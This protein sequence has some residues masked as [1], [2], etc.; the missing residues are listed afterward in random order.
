M[1][2]A[3]LIGGAV[4]FAWFVSISFGTSNYDLAGQPLGG[5]YIDF[6]AAGVTINRGE[7]DLLYDFDYQR[8]LQ[9]EI[10]GGEF[11][12]PDVYYALITPPHYSFPFIFLSRFPYK[13]SFILWS[14]LGLGFIFA[15]I[16][17]TETED[18]KRV[19]LWSLSYFPIFA[20]ISYGQNSLLSLGL[21][22]LVYFF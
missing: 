19:F 17:L 6:H 18:P 8:L 21:F 16:L 22:S 1:K 12:E 13:V 11:S 4:W 3:W 15:S 10:L 9:L 7:S 20:A 5:D 14:L 2:Y